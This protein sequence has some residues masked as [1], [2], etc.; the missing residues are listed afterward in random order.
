M[1]GED[2]GPNGTLPSEGEKIIDDPYGLEGFR[3]M[4]SEE[5]AASED[6]DADYRGAQVAAEE[7]DRLSDIHSRL[8]DPDI[9]DDISDVVRFFVWSNIFVEDWLTRLLEA[10]VIDQERVDAEIFE[11]TRS[12]ELRFNQIREMVHKAGLID[13]GLNAEIKRNRQ[14]RNQLV[15]DKRKRVSLSIRQIDHNNLESEVERAYNVFEKVKL[16]VRDVDENYIVE[17]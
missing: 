11:Y 6:F 10:G 12:G 17:S 9:R 3:Q 4:L 8:D 13:D 5:S 7:V 14:I 16:R 1:P 2:E 15:H